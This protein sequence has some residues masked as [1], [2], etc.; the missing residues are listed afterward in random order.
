MSKIVPCL[1]QLIYKA[2]CEII[3]FIHH[4]YLCNDSLDLTPL[5][6]VVPVFF[7]ISIFQCFYVVS[8][9]I[10]ILGCFS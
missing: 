3:H 2:I 7:I 9:Q 10:G 8:H 6:Y 1:G 4:W 5:S